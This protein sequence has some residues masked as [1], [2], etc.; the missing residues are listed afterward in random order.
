MGRGRPRLAGSLSAA[1]SP[2]GG[3]GRPFGRLSACSLVLAVAAVVWFLTEM[4]A[5]WGSPALGWAL[6]VT[7]ACL[8]V[9]ACWRASRTEG[10]SPGA[11]KFW[12]GFTLATG[13]LLL[14]L[15]VHTRDALLGPGAPT[16]RMSVATLG[17]YGVGALM[18]IWTVLRLPGLRAR[19]RQDP[20][21][22][23]LDSLIV[24]VTTALFMWHLAFRHITTWR[25]TAGSDVWAFLVVLI[26]AF[27]IL[28]LTKVA[29]TGPGP[30]NPRALKILS[31]A[32]GVGVVEG[33]LSPLLPDRQDLNMTLIG[34]PLT[35]LVLTLGAEYQRYAVRRGERVPDPQ[36]RRF[37]LIPYLAVAATDGLLL[38]TRDG[39]TESLVVAVGVVALTAVV[40]LRQ[41][42]AL[43]ENARLLQ[44]LD[45]NMLELRQAQEQLA[46]LA[47]HDPLTGLTNRHLFRERVA[48]ALDRCGSVTLALVDVDD[49][50]IVNDRYGHL[51]GDEVLVAVARRLRECTG[52][53]DTV[54]RLGGD[55]FALLLCG[56]DVQTARRALGRV[57]AVLGRSITANG[58]DITVGVSIGLAE[59][60]PGDRPSELLHR[61]D[62][63]MYAAK[64]SGKGRVMCYEPH[65]EREAAER[66]R[67]SA[68][69]RAGLERG[70]FHLVY[71]PLVRLPDGQVMGFEALVR[72]RHPGRGEVPPGV[73]IPIAERTGLIGPLG[74]WILREACEQAVRWLQA[75]GPAPDW[76][77]GVNISALQIQEPGFAEVLLGCLRETGLPP[78]RLAVEVTETALFDNDRAISELTVLTG[79]GVT[80]ALDDFGTGHSS[81]GLLQNVPVDALKVDKSFVDD[82]TTSSSGG[83]IASALIQIAEGLGLEAIA[84]GVETAEQ[85]EHLYRIG[86]RLAQGFYFARP[87]DADRVSRLL[88]DP[89]ALVS[90]TTGR[91]GGR[92]P[93]RRPSTP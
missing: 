17:L 29:L 80:V 74:A 44:Q 23:R 19:A 58:Q 85:A 27:V 10:I 60:A 50:K 42:F 52:P 37:S 8:P 6:T 13:A 73:F 26:G 84:E 1:E 5:P 34:Y 24:L 22:F 43:R 30:V 64:G 14:A 11:A 82:I 62:L 83:V 87:M 15:A 71:Q 49:F 32:C 2:G 88:A 41:V 79:F 65:L 66:D 7:S 47:T 76:R 78:D 33:A 38:C 77:I 57:T 51:A 92:V 72:W 46:H 21:R 56:V 70:E 45:A 35:A 18:G 91:D 86:Y 9:L 54:A 67:I 63:A 25:T 61:A 90:A 3:A 68:D 36:Q 40:V 89:S 55:E 20:S 31:L 12:F 69:L 4:R 59:A 48:R 16:Q 81:L 28:G 75:Q 53:D 39:S 93:R